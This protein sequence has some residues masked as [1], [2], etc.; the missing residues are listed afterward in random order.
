MRDQKG[1]KNPAW[2]GGISFN[3]ITG[4]Y[5]SIA[6][7]HPF[8]WENGRVLT[9]R[10]IYEKYLSE[11]AGEEVYIPPE[12]DI[13]HINGDK[14]DNRIENMTILFHGDH[15]TTHNEID[16]SYRTCYDCK[17][18]T[19]QTKKTKKGTIIPDWRTHPNIYGAFLCKRCA[20]RSHN[21]KIIICED[22]KE[23]RKMFAKGVCEKCYNR[24]ISNASPIIKCKGCGNTFHELD[25]N[26]KKHEYC[27][28]SCRMKTRND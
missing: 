19:P 28:R 14:T 20:Q 3:K 24:R 2:R 18:T 17:T 1:E 23:Y 8:A 11:L 16:M 4:Y 26:G 5:T 12:L 10:L 15:T 9:H 21:K 27:C 22:C 13:H 6:P 7:D 25:T